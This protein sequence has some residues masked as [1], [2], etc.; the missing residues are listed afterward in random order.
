V[1]LVGIAVREKSGVGGGGEAGPDSPPH[2]ANARQRSRQAAGSILTDLCNDGDQRKAG[3]NFEARKGAAC[4]DVLFLFRTQRPRGGECLD[5][6][7]GA[8]SQRAGKGLIAGEEI[9][10]EGTSARPRSSRV[11]SDLTTLRCRLHHGANCRR[12]L[13]NSVFESADRVDGDSDTVSAGESE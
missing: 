8:A 10:G 4:R 3:S 1:R 11:F 13:C 7:I 9:S 5:Q 2:E 12:R 6:T